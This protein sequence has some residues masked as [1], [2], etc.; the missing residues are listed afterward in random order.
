MDINTLKE[1]FSLEGKTALITGSGRGIGRGLAMA[2]SKSGADIV[3][4]DIIEENARET[5]ELIRSTSGAKAYPYV[6]DLSKIEMIPKYVQDILEDCGK[7]DILINNAGIQ[8]RKPALEFTLEEWNKVITIHLTASFAL[9]HAIVPSMIERRDGKIIN[10]SSVNS[11]MA[12]PNIMAYVAAKSGIAGMTR[13]MAVEWAEFDIRVNAIGPGFCRTALTEKLLEDPERT[14]WA[15]SRVPMKRFAE[16]EKDL[17]Y[18]AVFLASDAS[19]YITGQVIFV[20][21][22]LLA[23]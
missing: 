16:P 15:L 14:K 11:A 21:G 7:I 4:L 3:V 17:G 10:I 18:V 2:L 19:S 22:G 9:A 8:V 20:D 12:V 5:A 13:S 23:S 6:A 1:K